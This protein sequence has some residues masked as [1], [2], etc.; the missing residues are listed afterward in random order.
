MTKPD[1][2]AHTLVLMMAPREPL[3]RWCARG[4]GVREWAL[5]ERLLR[6]YQRVLFVTPDDGGI[7]DLRDALPDAPRDR[8]GLVNNRD[9]WTLGRYAD[10]LPAAM[11]AALR[12]ADSVVVKTSSLEWGEHAVH[13]VEVLRRAG[14]RVGL[15]ARDSRLWTK[16]VAAEQGPHTPD[17]AFAAEREEALCRGADVVSG[18]S[19]D[20]IND[21]AWRYGLDPA[22]CVVVPKFLAPLFPE[23]AEREP[24][25][26][27]AAGEL[28]RRKRVDLLVRAVAALP[29]AVRQRAR[30]EIVGDGPER[31]VLARLAA[32]L[33]APVVFRGELPYA[34]LR[35][36]FARAAIALQAST[37][38]TCPSHVFEAMAAGAAMLVTN[39]PGLAEMVTHGMNGLRLDPTPDAFA[40]AIEELLRDDDWRNVLGTAAARTARVEYSIDRAYERE[41]DL[42]R[43]AIELAADPARAAA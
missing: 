18:P 11:A 16:F 21:L 42:H 6:H 36:L 41:A 1:E 27:V 24:G 40:G 30:L 7:T 8:V 3:R 10:L 33:G 31:E 32:D 14:K 20:M 19:E 34:N 26:L 4:I 2:I 25:L 5:L 23:D 28:V 29:D 35:A 15:I 9:R 22:R 38:E 39:A 43:L 13:A 17:A 12:D 37:I